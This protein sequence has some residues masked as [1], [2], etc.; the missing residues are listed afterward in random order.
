MEEKKPECQETSDNGSTS[1]GVLDDQDELPE[2]SQDVA[3]HL[4]EMRNREA[5]DTRMDG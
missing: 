1:L 5:Q 4:D 3:E 2:I